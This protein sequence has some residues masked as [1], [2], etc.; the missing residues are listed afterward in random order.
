MRAL[1]TI[2]TPLVVFLSHMW[3]S[4]TMP[5]QAPPGVLYLAPHFKERILTHLA[6]DGLWMGASYALAAA[7]MVHVLGRFRKEREKAMAGAA[8]GTVIVG[9][10]YAFGCFMIGCCGSPMAAVWLGLLGGR[11]ANISGLFLFLVTL[12]STS[13]GLWM[14]NRGK[15]GKSK[16][17]CGKAMIS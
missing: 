2:T 4:V 17:E 3:W 6:G 14:L 16:V 1:L 15:S 8:G 12:I 13:A 9:G 7:F 5:Y 11:F 10:I